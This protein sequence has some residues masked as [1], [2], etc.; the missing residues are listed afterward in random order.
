MRLTCFATNAKD[1]RSPRWSYGTA[2]APVPRTASAPPEPPAC[3]TPLH[4][5]AQN[6]IWLEIV[7]TALDLFAWM[8]TRQPAPH[9][10]R[11]PLNKP[12]RPPDASTSRHERSRLRTS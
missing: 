11:T 8:P 4:D 1:N 6:Q 10:A 2:N 12:K 7:Q 5:T 9:P 3:A